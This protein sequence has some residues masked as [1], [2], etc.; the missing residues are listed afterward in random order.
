MQRVHVIQD[1][2]QPVE[3]VFAYL[4]EPKNLE[5]LFGAKIR[6]L[7]DG[8]DG[9]RNGVGATR[10]VK[11][12]LTPAA[13]ETNIEVVP[14]ELIHYQ[15]TKGG[16]LKDHDATMRFTRQENGSRLEYTIEFDG[17]VPG[18][19]PVAKRTLTR[20]IT[21]ALREYAQREP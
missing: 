21:R 16:V 12:A 17:K 11:V 13:V 1:F 2:P 14:N 10:E 3:E 6:R 7:S 5:A 19:G 15:I 8:A 18:I 9:T 20:N 4:S